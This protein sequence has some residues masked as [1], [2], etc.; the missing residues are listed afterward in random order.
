[1]GG[2]DKLRWLVPDLLRT[3]PYDTGVAWLHWHCCVPTLVVDGRQDQTCLYFCCGRVFSLDPKSVTKAVLSISFDPAEKTAGYMPG[4]R[5]R[6]T[7][8][9]ET[10]DKATS[11]YYIYSVG[12][13]GLR[14]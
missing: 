12:D 4:R 2:D 1:M 5:Y 8:P 9:S 10:L 6:V 3:E 14:P 7:L 13:H 11:E